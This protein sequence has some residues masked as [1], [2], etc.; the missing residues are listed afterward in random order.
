MRLENFRTAALAA[1]CLLIS[2]APGLAQ[3]K[4]G[5]VDFQQALLATAEMQKEAS[6][7][8]QKYKPDQDKLQALSQELQTIQTKLQSAQGE[9]AAKLQAEGQ[10]KQVDAQRLTEDLQTDIDFDRQQILE[11]GSQRM[12]TVIN[13]LRA[14]KGLDLIVDVTST[15]SFNSALDLTTEATAAYDAKHPAAAQ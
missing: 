9:E 5:I 8:E 1:V 2:A 7:L 4:I 14:S 12:R 6:K 11:G 10:E 15:L 13:E 3:A